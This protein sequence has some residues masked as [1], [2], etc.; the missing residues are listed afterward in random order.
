MKQSLKIIVI[1]AL[2]VA[3]IGSGAWLWRGENRSA[4]HAAEDHHEEER[5]EADRVELTARQIENAGLIMATAGPQKL[6]LGLTLY[7]RI[8]A[9]QDR[10][11]R[12]APRYPRDRA[13]GDE[14][15]RR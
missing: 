10:L 4:P 8:E 12:V 14:T 9:N 13:G 2:L 15:P 7:G 11:A 1:G 5:G 6:P 3:G